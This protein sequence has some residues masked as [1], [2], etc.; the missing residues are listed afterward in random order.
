[1]KKK[2]FTNEETK[3]TLEIITNLKAQINEKRKE[4]D[5]IQKKCESRIHELLVHNK[6]IEMDYLANKRIY[7]DLLF[8][9]TEINKKLRDL[10]DNHKTRKRSSE[11]KNI[12][13]LKG[14]KK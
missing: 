7:K 5:E 4:L 9:K 11:N 1:M 10:K 8:K 3:D 2:N 6:Q 14:D 12:N 13:I